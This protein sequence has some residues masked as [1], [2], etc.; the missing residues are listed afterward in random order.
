MVAFLIVFLY[1]VF[2]SIAKREIGWSSKD[3]MI[4]HMF[5]TTGR[6]PIGSKRFVRKAPKGLGLTH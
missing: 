6:M 2:R 1:V 4:C 5:N 3:L